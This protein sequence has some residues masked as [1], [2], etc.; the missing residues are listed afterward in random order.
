MSQQKHF[1][2]VG[3][4]NEHAFTLST[5]LAT[6]I[7]GRILR[8]IDVFDEKAPALNP[9]YSRAKIRAGRNPIR[10]WRMSGN[11]MAAF[12]VLAT[13]KANEVRVGFTNPVAAKIAAINNFYHPMYGA[14]PA[15]LGSLIEVL[16]QIPQRQL[17]IAA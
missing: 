6:S 16:R 17:L 1:V 4:S 5:A 8:G 7:K 10:D 11:T 13:T 15:D 2:Y 9:A 12:G 14:S 3:F